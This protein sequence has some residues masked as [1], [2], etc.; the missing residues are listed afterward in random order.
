M[1]EWKEL[2]IYDRIEM[3]FNNSINELRKQLGQINAE[4]KALESQREQTLRVYREYDREQ[5]DSD[6]E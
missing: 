2:N 3:D 4:I 1:A 6:S 5:I